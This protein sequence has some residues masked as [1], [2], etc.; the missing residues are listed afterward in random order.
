MKL[1]AIFI[2]LL[3]LLFIMLPGKCPAGT[4]SSNGLTGISGNTTR[5]IKCPPGKTSVKGSTVCL[6]T[7]KGIFSIDT[8]KNKQELKSVIENDESMC[9]TDD[10]T[11]LVKCSDI[12]SSELGELCVKQM[13]RDV[14]DSELTSDQ[15]KILL[16]TPIYNGTSCCNDEP[17]CKSDN[18]V[19][20][21]LLGN[22]ST[23][24][25]AGDYG[26]GNILNA[27]KMI[28]NNNF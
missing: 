17:K 8:P 9:Y 10:N 23:T 2:L 22:T 14:N 5:C 24:A 28:Y 21:R 12:P 11:E 25:C 20:T 7:C 13:F 16:K 4:F 26:A 1:I 6:D 19:N 18:Q 27:M 15:I 3:S